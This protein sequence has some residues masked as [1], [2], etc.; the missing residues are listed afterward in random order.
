VAPASPNL[1][2]NKMNRNNFW[3]WALIAFVLGWSLYEIYPPQGK[4]LLQQFSE[5]AGNR[6]TNFNAIVTRA[7]ELGKERPTRE[8]QNL[9]DAI[10]T[11]DLRRYF[12]AFRIAESDPKPNRTILN[13][14]QRE[15]AGNV[16]LGLDLQGGTAFMVRLQNPEPVVDPSDTNG[17]PDEVDR[18]ALADQAIEVLRKRVDAF[19]VAEPIIQK[20]GE[21][22]ILVQLPGLSEA[23]IESAR[24]AIQKAAFLEFRLVHP[25]S[26]EYLQQGITP[27][28]YEKLSHR[29]APKKPGEKEQ[30]S[31]YLVKKRPEQ[32]LIGKYV[33]SAGVTRD[34]VSNQPLI[35][36]RFDKEGA[37]IFGDVTRANVG[38]FL[39][40]VLDGE[41]YSAPRINDAITGGRAQIEGDFTVK[42]ALEL[43]HILQNPLEAP[44]EIE[45]ERAVDPSLGKDSIQSGVR[46]SIIAAILTFAFMLVFYFMAGMVANVALL[47]N[48]IILLGF[49]CS[50]DATLTLPGIAGIALTIGMAVDANV[51]IFERIREE[52]Q[53]GKSMR[54]A[55]AAGYDR[56]FGTIFDSNITTLITSF[57]LIWKGTGPVKGF[58]VTLSI[59]VIVSFFTALMVTRL[60]FNWMLDR[61]LIKSMKM[62]PIIKVP[63]INF[64][65]G[66]KIAVAVSVLAILIGTGYGIFVRGEKVL[67]VDFRGGDGTR[68]R[69][70]Q[71]VDVDRLRDALTKLRVGDPQIQ[72][73]R[74]VV[75]QSETLNIL[76][77]FGSSAQVET[78]LKQ[79]FPDAKFERVGKDVVGPSVGAEI[80]KSAIVSALL[81]FFGILFYVAFRYEFGF[82]VAAVVAVIHDVF[83]TM[84]IFFLAGGELSAPMVA[85]VLT[86]IGYSINDKIVILDRIREDLKLGVRGSFREIINLALNQTL[87]RTL[88]TGG[89]VILATLALYLFGG[90][91]INDFAFTFLVGVLVGTYSSIYIAAPLVLNWYKGEKP[92]LS[93]TT[94]VEEP[95]AAR[96]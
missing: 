42:E 26:D 47:L 15:A 49:M 87:S 10:G 9:V 50:I 83:V 80:Q 18:A 37:R 52:I 56:A 95:V 67:G 24:T 5:S 53:K 58:G 34:T 60:I 4:P 25:Q 72:Y 11:N 54:G 27:P 28:G 51:L 31:T 63:N 40:I 66:A 23:E 30:V 39:A 41:L 17:P 19:G 46:A 22:R 75:D 88:I 85:A 84:G 86:I 64:L 20:A 7:R 77:A 70:A 74:S 81:A 6:D 8:F 92:G 38:R 91:I 29:R 71:K 73:Q 62:M 93:K 2:L 3:K 90:G 59:G 35:T 33:T 82:A 57:I 78:A 61:G 94:I 65:G 36:M 96:A 76:T 16:K 79:Q 44:L 55:L 68:F 43:S 21:E 32:G 13:R 48:V 14:L 89:S 45:Y 1:L 12:P 69:F